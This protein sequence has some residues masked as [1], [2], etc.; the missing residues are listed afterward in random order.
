MATK[1]TDFMSELEAATRLKPHV[2]AN[3]FLLSIFALVAFF[4]IWASVSKIEELTRGSGQVVPSRE[5]QVVQ[6]LE[7]GILAELLVRE[8]DR[9]EKDQILMR[10]SDVAFS[11]EERGVEARSLG[12][13]AKKARLTA[14]ANGTAFVIPEDIAQQAPQVAAN[15]TALYDSRQKELGNAKSILEDKISKAEA[16]IAE[17][18]ADI[19]RIKSSRGLLYQELNITREMVKQRAVPKL[20]EIRLQ[21]EVSDLSGQL[22]ANEEKLVGLEAEL[23][24][25]KRELQDQDDKFT[26]QALGELNEVETEIRQLEE[27]L[28]SIG[29]RVFRAELR[30][31]VTGVINNIALTTI[32]GVVEPAHKLIE[33]VP[34]DDELKIIA[35]VRPSDIA[36][37]KPEQDVKVKVT[38]YDPQRYGSLKGKL[39]RI[40]ANSVT[41]R[42]GN[43]FFEIEVR[44][45]KNYLGTEDN[46]LPITPGMVAETEVITGKRT[47]MEY[48]IK[49]VLRAKDRALRE[50]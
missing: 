2:A 32:G 13:R 25:S 47:I 17:T 36:F 27:S 20:E 45:D 8:G 19:E 24:A 22:K 34:L 35:K 42:E 6:S 28:K 12:L 39:V 29:D 43:V 44:T 21:R 11:S 46:K 10:I 14:E 1:D 9:V 26:T 15:E 23:S 30:A 41:D 4:I 37:L 50:R 49:P 7:G 38:A 40:G 16:Q 33:I 5:V 3:I 48:L 18:N 31:P